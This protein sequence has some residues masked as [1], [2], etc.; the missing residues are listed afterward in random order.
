MGRLSTAEAFRLQA[1]RRLRRALPRKPVAGGRTPAFQ[2]VPT[3]PLFA[4]EAAGLRIARGVWEHGGTRLEVGEGGHPFSTTLPSERF[5]T[6]VHS[7]SWLPDLLGVEGGVAVARRLVHDWQAAFPAKTPNSFIDAPDLAAQRLFH[8]GWVWDDIVGQRAGDADT[9][10]ARYAAQMR[11]LRADA[12]ELSP[13]LSVLRAEAAGVMFGARHVENADAWLQRGLDRLDAALREQILPDGGHI[14]RSPQAT[15]QALEIALVT[16]GVL[17]ARGLSGSPAL[18]RAIDR[19]GPMIQTLRHTDGRLGVFHGGAEGSGEHIDA[20]L[21]AAPGEASAFA[22]GPHMGFHRVEAGETVLLVDTLGTPPRPY[23]LE[24]HLSPLAMEL[25]TAEG[26]LIVNC[27]HHPDAAPRWS[28][29]VRAAAAHSTLIVDGRSP[30]VIIEDGLKFDAFGPAVDVTPGEVRA[31]RKEQASGVWLE[32]AHDGYKPAYGLV[33]R[34]RLFV[35]DDG[36][37]VR[38][39]DSLFVPLGD[40]PVRRDRVPFTVRFHFH[41]DVRVSLAQ[42]LS[43]ALLV[44]KGRAGWRFRTDAGP[45]AVEPSVYLGG[46]AKPVRAQQLVIRGNALGDGDGQGR[47]NRVRWSLRRLKARKG[48]GAGEAAS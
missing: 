23:D 3:G 11:R 7:F 13:G 33:H 15:V 22:Y 29:P 27:G 21:E 44:L 18:G 39:E 41:P 46:S 9:L 16:D 14:T 1:R 25:S 42:D 12:S 19:L 26:R 6:W 32:T 4:N 34:R 45:L 8:W 5:A 47:D 24:A 38:G 48:A 37:D 20:L 36:D 10:R 40:A 30:G 28:R 35:G 2:P 17:S 43:S 31:R